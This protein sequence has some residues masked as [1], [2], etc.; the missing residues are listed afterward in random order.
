MGSNNVARSSTIDDGFVKL[1][2]SRNRESLPQVGETNF[3]VIN[4]IMEMYE[5]PAAV[6][7]RWLGISDKTAKRKLQFAR[8]LT[9]ED[10]GRLIRSERGFEVLEAVMGNAKPEW[11]R[12]VV[13]LMDAAQARKVQVAARRRLKQTIESALDADR[14]L[15][16]SIQYAEALSDQDHLSPHLDALRS[17]GGLQD[18]SLASAKRKR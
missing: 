7:G 18:R 12:V 3:R 16:A 14:H 6:F 13:P 5:N 15:T 9:V 4:K 10:L 2:A 1:P 8:T 11:W 17:M